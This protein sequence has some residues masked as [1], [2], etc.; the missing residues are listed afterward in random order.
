MKQFL[1]LLIIY[2]SISFAMQ[3]LL[4]ADELLLDSLSQTISVNKAEEVLAQL[5]KYR[6]VGY[7]L[8]PVL[9][10]LKWLLVAGLLYTALF[11]ANVKTSFKALW[12]IALQAEW[13][14]VAAAFIK[15]LW[16]YLV[17]TNYT[18]E[19]L[20][21]FY[22]LSAANLFAPNELEAWWVYPFQLINLFEVAYWVILAILLG[23]ALQ[24]STGKAAEY[25]IK[26]YGSGL[27]LWVLLVVFITLNFS[28]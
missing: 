18:L 14:F 15:F 4:P 26:G 5:V 19:D 24:I 8:S 9:L 28:V 6:W 1:L 16:F 11:F 13:V 17:S 10:L 20:Q 27:L 21:F 23:R 3:Y 25:V 22:P 2:L 7:V 12:H